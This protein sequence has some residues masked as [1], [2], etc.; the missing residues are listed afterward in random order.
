MR[1]EAAICEDPKLI[2]LLLTLTVGKRINSKTTDSVCVHVCD[3][4]SEY[5]HRE[6]F[7]FSHLPSEKRLSTTEA[8]L[9]IFLSHSILLTHPLTCHS[10][11]LVNVNTPTQLANQVFTKH[12]K[13]HEGS[14]EF[15]QKQMRESTSASGKSSLHRMACV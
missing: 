9:P 7:D 2:I 13:C 6:D 3:V 10:R 1:T 14:A 11:L 5:F 4:Y 12:H 8:M 15:T